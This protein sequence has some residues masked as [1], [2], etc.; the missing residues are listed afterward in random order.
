MNP[1]L[2]TL[3]TPFE[4][5]PFEKLNAEH[6]LPA[7]EEGIKQG[8]ADIDIIVNNTQAPNFDNTIAALD[9]SGKLL[10]TVS[11][12]F[13]NL[14]EAE[15]N[16]AL[17]NLAKEISPKLT[18][19]GNDIMLNEV[20]FKRVETVYLNR[21]TENLTA[22]QTTLL[23]KTYKSFVRNGSKLNDD[24]KAKLREIDTTLATTCLT[25]GEHVLAESNDYQL[26]INDKSLLS[27]LP[28]GT[29][30]AAKLTAKEK[31][32]DDAWVF[33]LDYPSYIPFVTYSDQR[34]LRE[35]I[36]LAFGS[37]AFK[38][39][40]RNNSEVIKKIA[41][42]RHQRANLLGYA[43][44]ADFVLEERMAKNPTT[45]LT[46]LDEILIHALPAAKEELTELEAFSQSI[47][48]PVKLERWDVPYYAEK[49]KKEKFAIDDELLKPY[50]KLEN[51]IDG[52]FQTAGKLYNLTF[53]LNNS[54]EKYH[55]EVMTYEVKNTSNEHVAVLYMDFFPRAGKRQ[56]AWMT[57]F[58]NQKI[59]NGKNVRPHISIVC[60]FTKPTENKPSLL[61][62][63]EV[64][65]LFHEFGHALHGMCANGTYGSITGTSVYWDFVELPSQILENWCYEKECL[66]LFAKHYETGEAI[67]EEYI[68]KIVDSANFQSGLA[69]IRQIGLGKLDMAWHKA[70]PSGITDIKQFEL[71]TTAQTDLYPTVKE[72]STSCSFSH[73]FQ[74]GYSSGYYS[75][76]WAEVIDAD[77]F[78]AFKEKGIF[79]Q[80]VAQ[81]FYKNI[82]SAGGSEHPSILYRRFRGRDADPKALLRRE[83]LIK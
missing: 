3:E 34:K 12:I 49:L 66:D 78:E 38:A 35:E 1:F 13:F 71:D 21:S 27:G 47:G 28:E 63:N 41:L 22:E 70:D 16:E 57:S 17:Q 5:F 25:F 56:G 76:K 6:Y 44:H 79:N 20:L 53:E 26:V 73:I 14:H 72:T 51:V 59:E 2:N 37:K 54:I 52:V 24:A 61:T 64:T 83:G 50:F 48:G 45:V 58:R 74:G 8:K 31:G 23:E 80:E 75:Y 33:T 39:N 62:F 60:N 43:S 42:L 18:E 68:Q 46:F 40:E 15:T 11:N 67:P 36:F 19:F 55:P 82:L 81:S 7:L 69:A 77:A 29:V 10:D 4:T 9:N 30:E 65:T 32:L